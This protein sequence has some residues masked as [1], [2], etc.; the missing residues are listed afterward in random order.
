MLKHCLSGSYAKKSVFLVAFMM[1][2]LLGFSRKFYFSAAGND[3]YSTTQAQNPATPWKTLAKLNSLSGI[4][5]AGDTFAFKRGEIFANGSQG[6]EY[7][8]VGSVKWYKNFEGR[9][10]PSGTAQNPIVFTYYGDMNLERPNLL[11]PNPTN[12]T[13]SN[14]RGV[15]AFAGVSYIV[16]DGIQFNDTRFPFLDKRSGAYT[17]QGLW[18]GDSGYCSDDDACKCSN[19]TVKNCNFSNTAYG[20]VAFVRD[21]KIENNTF[22]NFKSTGWITDTASQADIGADP[23]LLSGSKYRITNNTITGS[24][25]YANPFNSSSSGL[26]GGAVETINNFDSSFVGYNTFV[27]CSGG[28]EFGTNLPGGVQGPDD[29]TICYNKFVNC[30]NIGYVNTTGTYATQVKNIH[31]WNNFFVE[32]SMSRFSGNNAGGD[33]LGDGQTYTSTGFIYWPPY[34]LNKSIRYPASQNF[35]NAWRPIAVGETAGQNADTVFDIRN[36]VFWINNGFYAKYSTGERVKVFYRNNIYHLVSGYQNPAEGP[37]TATS[38]GTSGVTLATGEKIRNGKMIVDSSSI[39]PQ[40]WDMRIVSDTAYAAAGGTNVGL[41][42]DF[43]GNVVGATPSIGIFQYVT[44]YGPVV[45]SISPTSGSLNQAVTIRGRNFTGATSVLLRT[46][47]DGSVPFTVINDST[48]VATITLQSSQYVNAPNG[49]VFIVTNAGGSNVSSS[50]FIYNPPITPAC[51]FVYDGWRTCSNGV[52]TRTYLT[53]PSGCAGAPPRDS[54]TRSCTTPT[55]ASLTF[56]ASLSAILVNCNVAGQLSIVNSSGQIVLTLAYGPG[57]STISVASLAPG[58]YT[59]TTFGTSVVFATTVR[60]TVVSTTRPTCRTST[61]GQI[62]VIGSLG[63]APYTYSINSTSNYGSSGTFSNLRR[64]TYSIRC[65]DANGIV[66]S[67]SV[68][69]TKLSSVCN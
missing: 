1:I 59:A 37:F 31:F 57:S 45:T 4:A 66:T 30:S 32:G 28:F 22:S 34:P 11:Y 33:A 12:T 17:T 36:N 58:N 16:I 53:S 2:A 25:A 47:V 38:L 19:I 15:L 23:M 52:E 56:S 41:T 51:T 50:S 60:V 7:N 69:L 10:F 18:F 48:I 39:F 29:D 5:A 65:K 46:A 68:T 67:I 6:G 49:G 62:V 35:Q 44:S 21:F 55:I 20:I 42:R 43:A 27:D 24:W 54:I 61:N 3:S 13:R 26:L 14:E 64:G 40:N 63:T 8:I 9:N